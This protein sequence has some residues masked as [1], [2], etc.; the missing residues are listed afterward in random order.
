MQWINQ[1]QPS[2]WCLINVNFLS[3]WCK[4]SARPPPAPPLGFET[5]G[6]SMHCFGSGVGSCLA[7]LHPQAWRWHLPVR[8]RPQ[9]PRQARERELKTPLASS[10][11]TPSKETCPSENLPIP[12]PFSSA[13]ICEYTTKDLPSY[14]EVSSE[15][16]GSGC[17]RELS[18]LDSR[19]PG[20]HPRVSRAQ[21][22]TLRTVTKLCCSLDPPA[23]SLRVRMLVL[24]LAP[25]CSDSK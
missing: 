13:F 19:H 9:G 16:E 23:N 24:L 11:G 3:S 7:V 4:I 21:G 2:S 5:L 15:V 22:R 10:P 25:A 18:R 20:P 8:Y 1:C 17:R 12:Y 14:C 6:V